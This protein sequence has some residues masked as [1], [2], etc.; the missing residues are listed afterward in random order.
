MYYSPNSLKAGLYRGY[1][2][3]DYRVYGYSEFRLWLI[4]VGEVIAHTGFRD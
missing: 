3:D 2:W 4:W 1:T